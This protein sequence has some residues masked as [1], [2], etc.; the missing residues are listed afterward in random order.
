M[1]GN[2]LRERAFSGAVR[3]HDSVNL[4]SIHGEVYPA[5]YFFLADRGVKVFDFE[6]LISLCIKCAAR[7][8]EC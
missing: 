1:T 6:H 4:A 7:E 8:Q 5:K 2:H 3:S